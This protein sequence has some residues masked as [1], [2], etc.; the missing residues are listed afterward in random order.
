MDSAL[1]P[2]ILTSWLIVRDIIWNLSDIVA[3]RFLVIVLKDLAR[4]IRDCAEHF[5]HGPV[6]KCSLG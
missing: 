5:D 3:S 1:A 2:L 4:I 6:Q